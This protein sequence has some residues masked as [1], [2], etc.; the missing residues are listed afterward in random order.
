MATMGSAGASSLLDDELDEEGRKKKAGLAG[1][2]PTM[3]GPA[4]AFDLGVVD[5]TSTPPVEMQ[6]LDDEEERKRMKRQM[7]MGGLSASGFD[8]LGGI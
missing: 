8:L 6:L 3:G 7:T 4:A 5:P 1:P 2:Q